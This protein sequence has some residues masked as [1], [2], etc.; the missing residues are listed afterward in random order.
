MTRNHIARLV[1]VGKP[2]VVGDKRVIVC[3]GTVKFSVF[4]RQ[5]LHT[6]DLQVKAE[7]RLKSTAPPELKMPPDR[8]LPDAVR[9]LILHN[10]VP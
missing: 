8:E 4:N 6:V 9:A 1:G 2:L 7:Q 10:I 5:K 3:H